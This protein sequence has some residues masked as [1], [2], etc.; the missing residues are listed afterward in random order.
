MDVIPD[1]LYMDH[2]TGQGFAS[3]RRLAKL[4]DEL[5]ATIDH[6]IK[7]DSVLQSAMEIALVQTAVGLKCVRVHPES[8]VKAVVKEYKPDVFEIFKGCNLDEFLDGLARSAAASS[9]YSKKNN[10]QP[11]FTK[12]ISEGLYMDS[13]GELFV[14]T[15]LLAAFTGESRNTVHSFIESKSALRTVAAFVSG[16]ITVRVHP[17]STVRSVIEEYKPDL[18]DDFEG[19]G[20][21]V[22]LNGLAQYSTDLAADSVPGDAQQRWTLYEW[23]IGHCEIVL[24]GRLFNQFKSKV[25]KVYKETYRRDPE[26]RYRNQANNPKQVSRL[27]VY[28][29]TDFP[30]LQLCYL[31]TLMEVRFK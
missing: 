5:D 28:A 29:P 13:T 12:S 11:Y 25:H 20:F 24:S 3:T 14:S 27:Q 8:T 6:F 19:C 15:E 17:E 22:F 21:L 26:K 7:A 9:D 16:V 4:V 10:F 1:G 18:A 30:I 23:M 31:Q 2:N